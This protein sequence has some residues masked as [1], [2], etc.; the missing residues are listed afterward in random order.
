[1]VG[2]SYHELTANQPQQR[3]TAGQ[4]KQFLL[5]CVVGVAVCANSFINAGL[6]EP[7]VIKNDG[8][9]PGGDFVYKLL[10]DRDFATTGGIWRRIAKD[11]THDDT[12][13]LNL[14]N[15][16]QSNKTE[17]TFDS[18]LYSVYID[19][20][21]K[22]WGRYFAGILIDQS[23]TH[24]KDKLLERNEKIQ[25]MSEDDDTSESKF[26][27]LKYE[28]GD[29]PSVRSAI[30]TF[31]FTNGFISALLHNYKVF[32]ALHKYAKQNHDPKS[33][34]VISTTCNRKLKLCQHYVPMIESEKF[35]LGEPDTE[36]YLKKK[37]NDALD[38]EK[39]FKGVKKLV[40]F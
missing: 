35:L 21:N 5:I 37:P 1:M 20:V 22:G 24:L 27:R 3:N 29:L 8:I 9:Y 4:R 38:L 16:D 25:Y 23:K 12:P 36:E 7:V 39:M 30:T 26:L 2:V 15:E 34:I 17:E 10:Q 18:M 11:L 31:P 32:P 6:F 40:G 28:V 19:N 33:K 14:N 13:K